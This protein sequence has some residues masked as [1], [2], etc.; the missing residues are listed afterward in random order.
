MREERG[1]VG[2]RSMGCTLSL[3]LTTE[4]RRLWVFHYMGTFV[5]GVI[6]TYKTW[7]GEDMGCGV[8]CTNNKVLAGSTVGM[9]I[10]RKPFSKF[11]NSHVSRNQ[12]TVLYM[13]R[14]EVE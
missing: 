2:C 7:R 3:A 5:Y 12:M 11:I 1:E 8:E 13:T 9:Q 4:A 10:D 6:C 14:I